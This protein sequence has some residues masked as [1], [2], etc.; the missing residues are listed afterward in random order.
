MNEDYKNED[1]VRCL[2]EQVG[3]NLHPEIGTVG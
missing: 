3:Y 2:K 1:E